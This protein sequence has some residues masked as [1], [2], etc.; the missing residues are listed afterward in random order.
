MMGVKNTMQLLKMVRIP[1]S[2]SLS[3]L[4]KK[5]SAANESALHKVAVIVYAPTCFRE[6]LNNMA[7][8]FCNNA[9]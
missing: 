7:R 4:I 3:V 8:I 1:I 9:C 5:G 6:S 2:P